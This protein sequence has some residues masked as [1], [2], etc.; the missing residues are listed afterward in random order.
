M[1]KKKPKPDSTDRKS[2]LGERVMYKLMFGLLFFLTTPAKALPTDVRSLPL[3]Q[4]GLEHI[5][6]QGHIQ[7]WKL[8][9]ICI[10]N[11]AYLLLLQG[12]KEDPISISASFKNGAPEQ[13]Q[14]D[15]SSDQNMSS[16]SV[17]AIKA[18][19]NP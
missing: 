6:I 13:C 3:D 14:V 7:T 2:I 16:D 1:K 15:S 12:I 9:K 17:K 11:Q 5:N 4:I 10:D 8:R 19:P 18:K